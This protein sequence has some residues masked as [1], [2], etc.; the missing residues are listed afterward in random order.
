MIAVRA[1]FR[2]DVRRQ[3]LDWLA[4]K[5]VKLPRDV[6][7]TA[8]AVAYFKLL[9]ETIPPLP[10]RVLWSKELRERVLTVEQLVA[11]KRV[12]AEAQKGADLNRRLTTRRLDPTVHDAQFNE[13]GIRHLH[14]GS[15]RRRRSLEL[16]YVHVDNTAIRFVDFGDH[17]TFGDRHLFNVLCRNWPETVEHARMKTVRGVPLLPSSGP[18]P[19]TKEYREAWA[20]GLTVIIPVDDGYYMPPGGGLTTAGVGALVAKYANQFNNA[21]WN[22]ELWFRENATAVQRAI[23]EQAGFDLSEL[24]LKAELC[25]D[26]LLIREEQSLAKMGP[27]PV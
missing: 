2:E 14:L 23:A 7:F 10:R 22:L 17:N 3:V 9:H 6:T 12:Q 21:T 18:G 25:S 13:W 4:T 15:G 26:G 16:L 5:G 8:A 11:I 27:Y 20:R 19:S 24:H 1:D